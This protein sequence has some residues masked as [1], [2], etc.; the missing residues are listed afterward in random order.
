V[1]TRICG[2]AFAEKEDDDRR[3]VFVGEFP[4]LLERHERE[5]PTAVMAD[6]LANRAC[7]RIVGPNVRRQSADP[8]SGSEPLHDQEGSS[9]R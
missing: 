5:Q 1:S 6:A 8:A 4:K 7:R 3:E 2:I 9:R